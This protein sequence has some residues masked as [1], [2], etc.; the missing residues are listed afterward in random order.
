MWLLCCYVSFFSLN[1]CFFISLVYVCVSTYVQNYRA[2][3]EPR[4]TLSFVLSSL[5]P[6]RV[7]RPRISTTSIRLEQHNISRLRVVAGLQAHTHTSAAWHNQRIRAKKFWFIANL[8]SKFN[9]TLFGKSLPNWITLIHA[10]IEIR[11]V[12]WHMCVALIVCSF[13]IVWICLFWHSRHH[14]III[15]LLLAWSISFP[16]D[17]GAQ[18]MD[19]CAWMDIICLLQLEHETNGETALALG[20]SARG[21][22][23][24]VRVCVPLSLHT[25]PSPSSLSLSLAITPNIDLRAAMNTEIEEEYYRHILVIAFSFL[26]LFLLHYALTLTL[27]T[28]ITYAVTVDMSVLLSWDGTKTNLDYIK[29]NRSE[30]KQRTHIQ[31]NT[32]F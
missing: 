15:F 9:Q 20:C 27:A 2:A 18:W 13:V 6:H 4:I 19:I 12:Y 21:L 26:R 10:R 29:G 28:T 31:H 17:T 8:R 30:R 16:F 32:F 1:L 24:L 11:L 22:Q 23:S 25:S 5:S 3:A 7:F 14:R